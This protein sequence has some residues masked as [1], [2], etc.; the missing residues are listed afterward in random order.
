MEPSGVDAAAFDPAAFRA[1]TR[2]LLAGPIIYVPIRHHSPACAQQARQIIEETSPFA[3]LVE[4]APSFD[5]QIELICDPTARMPLAIYSYAAYRLPPRFTPT[6]TAGDDAGPGMDEPVR[7]GSYFPLC[8]YSPEV[9]AL[10]AGKQAGARLGFIDL[11]YADPRRHQLGALP[12]FDDDDN[13][14]AGVETGNDTETLAG[15]SSYA[16]ETMYALSAAMTRVAEQI[17]CRDHND[18]WDQMVES[19]PGTAEETLSAVLAYASLARADAH[20]ERLN[21][22]GTHQREAAMANLIAQCIRDRD[23]SGSDAPIVVV[24]GA[25]HTVALPELVSAALTRG[26]QAAEPPTVQSRANAPELVE[27]GHGLIRYSFDRLDALAGYS[28][29]M[30]SPRWYQLTWDE[31]QSN[32]PNDGLALSASAR[33]IIGSVAAEL[34]DQ[35]SDGQPSVPTV[36]DAM[37]ACEQLARLRRRPVATRNDVVD[38]MVSCFTKA[39]DSTIN[40]VRRVA[41]KQMVGSNLGAVPASTPRVPLARDFDQTLERLGLPND[42]SEQKS[43]N[44]DVYRSERDRQ[45]SRVLHGL[46]A[47]GVTYGRCTRPLRYSRSTGRDVIRE[48]WTVRLDGATDA[49]LVEASLWGAS[50]DEAVRAL[51]LHQL[52]ELLDEQPGAGELMRMVMIAAQRGVHDAVEIALNEVR[53]RIGIDPSLTEVASALTEAEMIWTAR[54]PLG[55]SA[56]DALPDI[57]EQLYVRA[58]QLGGRLP[59]ISEDEHPQAVTDL[60]TIYRALTTNAWE[61]LDNELFWSMVASVRSTVAAGRLRGAVTGLEWRGDRCSDD[62]L[63]AQVV[64]HIDPATDHRVGSEFLAGVITVAREAFWEIGSIVTALSEALG[65]YDRRQFVRRIPGLRAAFA[66]LTPRQTDRIA[67]VIRSQT[68]ARANVQVL[69]IEE[70][71]VLNHTD[72]SLATIEQFEADGL[73]HWLTEPEATS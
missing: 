51:T 3:V 20:P 9:A 46:E 13:H 4:G 11:D 1:R 6:A 24:T 26:E 68:G 36:V 48:Q 30:P 32:V 67:E 56:L 19:Q 14:D 58:C 27:H 41:A 62:E 47:L 10:R 55:G 44:L 42:T 71:Q 52:R 69:G 33:Q 21:T 25:F 39:E 72:L 2:E 70:H 5:D 29:G 40:P 34:R 35:S 50:I 16:D 65:S 23:A 15:P 54:E 60:L 73:S 22:D 59:T 12:S 64:G 31:M 57:A 61:D 49:S 38:A 45:K 63:T 53:A 18:L 28:A 7:A 8:D 66:D 43:I 37:T 17:G